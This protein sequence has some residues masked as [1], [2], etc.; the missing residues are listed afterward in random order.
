MATHDELPSALIKSPSFQIERV[1]RH[2]KDE[3]E[4]T[5]CKHEVSMRGFWVLTLSLIHI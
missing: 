4:R 2:T 1:R 5:L 3:V